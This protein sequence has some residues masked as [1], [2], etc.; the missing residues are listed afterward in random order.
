MSETPRAAS[1]AEAPERRRSKSPP[2]V[3]EA[4]DDLA[5][6]ALALAAAMP[7]IR[8][9]ATGEAV[10]DG[11]VP[12]PEHSAE[13]A[14]WLLE[15]HACIARAAPVVIDAVR[16]PGGPHAPGAEAGLRGAR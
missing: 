12:V 6:A 8:A 15:Q 9:V 16:D 13:R 10:L 14:A 5:G 7:D 11:P 3:G 1:E 2:G 4:C